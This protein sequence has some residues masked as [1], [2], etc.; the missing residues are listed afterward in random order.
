MQLPAY[1]PGVYTRS[2]LSCIAVFGCGLHDRVFSPQR[3]PF[4]ILH[5]HIRLTTFDHFVDAANC[6]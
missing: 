2:I 1:R 4:V 3:I 6:S 5:H